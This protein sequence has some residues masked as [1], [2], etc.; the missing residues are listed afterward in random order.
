MWPRMTLQWR[1]FSLR[2][3]Q[4]GDGQGAFRGGAT[5]WHTFPAGVVLSVAKRRAPALLEKIWRD[6]LL[7]SAIV[8][9]ALCAAVLA[10]APV[11]AAAPAKV[12]DHDIYCTF[13]PWLKLCGPA[14]PAAAVVVKPVAKAA[15]AAKPVVVASAKVAAPKIKMMQCEK[16]TDGKPFLLSCT[17]K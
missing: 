12:T 2:V 6:S 11:Q 4:N 14:K 8:A 7:K 9:A 5:A 16:R 13:M 1:P 3:M 15:P 10:T 17:Y